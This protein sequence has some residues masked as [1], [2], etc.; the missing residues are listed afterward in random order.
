M[1]EVL[2][3]S[4][5]PHKK[6]VSVFVSLEQPSC[7]NFSNLQ[8]AW[9]ADPHVHFVRFTTQRSATFVREIAHMTICFFHK[10]TSSLYLVGQDPHPNILVTFPL[11]FDFLFGAMVSLLVDNYWL[12]LS[13]MVG[14]FLLRSVNVL[15][16]RLV[17]L[18]R[19]PSLFGI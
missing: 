12:W 18:P 13:V 17:Q 19:Q 6:N 15:T 5:F 9:C 11:H 2:I 7:R 4:L 1:A 8:D 3:Y 10:R 14:T 16:R